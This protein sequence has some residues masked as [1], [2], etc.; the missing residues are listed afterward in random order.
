MAMN[1]VIS[2][3]GVP[4]ELLISKGH[5]AGAGIEMDQ[6]PHPL[7]SLSLATNPGRGEV[8]AAARS[9]VAGHGGQ[10]IVYAKRLAI[11][12]A[13]EWQ[14]LLG[15]NYAVGPPRSRDGASRG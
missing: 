8:N 2:L 5:L 6:M 9:P 12:L 7:P 15:K 14:D 13:E 1:C 11:D 10:A 4:P 3:M